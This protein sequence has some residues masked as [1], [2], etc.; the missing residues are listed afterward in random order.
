MITHS[1]KDGNHQRLVD[2]ED[3]LSGIFPHQL[4]PDVSDTL[5]YLKDALRALEYCYDSGEPSFF[6][7]GEFRTKKE[8]L[9]S[10]RGMEKLIGV[11]A[12]DTFMHVSVQGI[13]F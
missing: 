4:A 7:R 9:D 12:K 1:V 8:V 13:L 6:S 5:K 10:I 2:L 11:E 3:S